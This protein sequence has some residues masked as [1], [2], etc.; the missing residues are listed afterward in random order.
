[1]HPFN[2]TTNSPAE[3]DYTI[4][5]YYIDNTGVEQSGCLDLE[6]AVDKDNDEFYFY[7]T[8]TSEPKDYPVYIWVTSDPYVGEFE[9]TITLD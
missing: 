4:E 8:E 3:C 9:F 7:I 2:F 1:M 5:P 6:C